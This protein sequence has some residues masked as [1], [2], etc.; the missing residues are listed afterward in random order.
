LDITGQKYFV[1]GKTRWA[2]AYRIIATIYLSIENQY[3]T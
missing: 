3:I 2:N 1:D